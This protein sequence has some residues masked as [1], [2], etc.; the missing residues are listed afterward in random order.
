MVDRA[1]WQGARRGSARLRSLDGRGRVRCDP[2]R[3]AGG[4]VHAQWL[5]PSRSYRNRL[6]GGS[7]PRPAMAG[8]QSVSDSRRILVYYRRSADGRLV[9][10]G[11]GRMALPSSAS[12]WA[13]LERALIRLYPALAGIAIEKRWFGRVAMTPD[14]LP[15]LYEPEK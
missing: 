9:L 4:A 2:R 6:E 7:Q 14:H 5:D 10:G 1:F 8:A 11:R 13:H 12:D 3:E 15:H